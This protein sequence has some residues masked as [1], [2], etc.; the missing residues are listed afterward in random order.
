MT[1]KRPTALFAGAVLGHLLLTWGRAEAV[2]TGDGMAY[3]L[4]ADGAWHLVASPFAHRVLTPFLAST[5]P[6]P[7]LWAFALVAAMFTGIAFVA[8]DR[9][10]RAMF[11]DRIVLLGLAV[12][13]MSG[14]LALVLEVPSYID[15]GTLAAACVVFVGLQE[16]RWMLVLAAVA[17]GV[18][19]HEMALLLLVPTGITAWRERKLAD[20]VVVGVVGVGVWWFLHRSG[21]VVDPNE[22]PNL[23]DAEWRA[24]VLAV[25][26]D[27]FNSVLGAI[28]WHARESYGVAWLLAPLGWLG[29]RRLVR[30]GA[31]MLPLCVVA[32]LG[33][34]NWGRMFTPA[35]P[36][37][38]ALAC[39]AVSGRGAQGLGEEAGPAG[40]VE[41]VPSGD[42][43]T[44]TEPGPSRRVEG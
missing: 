27:E 41:L 17:L 22:A 3:S 16:K 30:D 13:A 42:A 8:L 23:L 6:I 24:E 11:P 18:A 34:S 35:A 10:L 12:L 9:F 33:A 37:I 40:T 43:G 14:P 44:A 5:L 39:A 1:W 15:A 26:V 31:W 32:C 4:M 36:V 19:N 25:N 38:I 7:D 20:G 28:W 29:A 2:T 21:L